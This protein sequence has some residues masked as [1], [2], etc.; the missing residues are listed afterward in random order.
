MNKYQELL[1]NLTI[2]S[3]KYDLSVKLELELKNG[4]LTFDTEGIE[5][6]F[7][8]ANKT[9]AII[10]DLSYAMIEPEELSVFVKLIHKSD[11]REKVVA[12]I[13]N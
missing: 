2:L 9:D 10:N 12:M 5:I 6:I 1:N 11:D 13:A 7:T 8:D 4:K 3:N